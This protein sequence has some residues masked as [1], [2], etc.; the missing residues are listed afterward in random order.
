MDLVFTNGK[1]AESMRDNINT[2]KNMEKESIF[3]QMAEFM[4]VNGLMENN[5]A[6][7]NIFYQMGKLE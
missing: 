4:M 2:I 3:G 1:M 7:A 5:M 6:L